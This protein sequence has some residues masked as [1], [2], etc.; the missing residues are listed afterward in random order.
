M[1]RR[2]LLGPAR[3]LFVAGDDAYVT[4]PVTMTAVA[5]RSGRPLSVAGDLALT[6]R[7]VDGRWRLSSHAWVRRETAS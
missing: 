3:H 4:L 2:L 1:E 5:L 6:L 7:R